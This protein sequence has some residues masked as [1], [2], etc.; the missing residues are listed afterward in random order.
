MGVSGFPRNATSVTLA[1]YRLDDSGGWVDNQRI[2]AD[3]LSV[4]LENANMARRYGAYQGKRNYEG[5]WW[6]STNHGHVP[7]ESLLERDYLL[8][9]DWDPRVV[10]V[11]AQPIALLWPKDTPHHHSHVPDYFVRLKD[12]TG[13]LVDVKTPKGLSTHARDQLALTEAVCQEVG[14]GYEVFTGLPAN[15]A[16]NLRWLAGYRQDRNVAAGDDAAAIHDAFA[17]G[18]ALGVGVAA[19]ARATGTLE[20]VLRANTYHMLFTHKLWVDTTHPLS[21]RSQVT[22]WP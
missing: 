9:A 12:G 18:A 7:F 11:A 1:L 17:N 21:N 6:S 10:R 20:A 2:T 13:A 22:P 4:P 16:D 3:L 14:W 8:W 19:A 5:L 15:E